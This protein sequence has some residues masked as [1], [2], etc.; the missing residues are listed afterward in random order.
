MSILLLSISFFSF[1][2][3]KVY[4]HSWKKENIAKKI[5][6]LLIEVC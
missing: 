2:Y 5:N 4:S 6:K 1:F 3:A